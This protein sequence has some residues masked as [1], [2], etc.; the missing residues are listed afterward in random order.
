MIRRRTY[1]DCSAAAEEKPALTKNRF[2]KLME[3][4]QVV[5]QYSPAVQHEQESGDAE[6]ANAFK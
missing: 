5:G 6:D 3:D 4:S 2:L 1:G